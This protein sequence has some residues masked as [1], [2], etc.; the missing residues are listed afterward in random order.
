MNELRAQNIVAHRTD[1]GPFKSRDDLKKV[2]SIGAKTFE[3]CAGFIR[4]DCTTA[5]L[6]G[7]YNIL[8]STWVHPESYDLTKKLINKLKL[9]LNDVGTTAFIA[10]IRDVQQ[11]SGKTA[12]LAT[13]FRVPEER[14]CRLIFHRF[15]YSNEF[16]CLNFLFEFFVSSIGQKYL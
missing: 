2:K 7:E 15:V 10:K 5:N 16:S 11:E 9:S 3:Q 14:V 1:N 8:D 6:N 12:R 13:E 4:I